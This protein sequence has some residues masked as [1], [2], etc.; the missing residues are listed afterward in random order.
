MAQLRRASR[1]RFRKKRQ[2]PPPRTTQAN[3][4]PTTPMTI[5]EALAA[6]IANGLAKLQPVQTQMTN[7]NKNNSNTH[8]N[9]NNTNSNIQ[10]N[11]GSDKPRV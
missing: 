11:I 1:A 3:P 8:N 5:N 10:N 2:A 7:E 4:K 6:A 9:N